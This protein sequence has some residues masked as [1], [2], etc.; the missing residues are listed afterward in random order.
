[1]SID[2]LVF[3]PAKASSH[4]GAGSVQIAGSGGVPF[5]STDQGRLEPKCLTGRH[6][7]TAGQQPPARPVGPG[8]SHPPENT[9][10]MSGSQ[11]E[12]DHVQH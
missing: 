1:M 9:T 2:G 8:S 11:S 12:I 3:E 5:S 4:D 7:W 6:D 10:H